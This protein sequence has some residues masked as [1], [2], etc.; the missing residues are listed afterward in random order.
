MLRRLSSLVTVRVLCVSLTLLGLS[1]VV[2]AESKV[3]SGQAVAKELGLPPDARHGFADADGVPIHFVEIG[4]GPLLIMIHGF[5][6]YWYSWRKQMPKLSETHHV[7]AIDQRGYNHSGQPNG[8]D[9]YRMDRLVD[10]I[11]AVVNHFEEER[12]IIVGHDWGG[13]VAW[14]TAMEHPKL[15]EQLVI[16]NLPHPQ[17]LARELANNAQQQKASGYARFFQTEAAAKTLS[18][19]GLAFWVNDVE[20]RKHY[21][22]AFERSSFESMLNYYKANYPKEPYTYN[23]DADV[24]LIKCPVLMIHGLKDSALLPGALNDTWRYLERDLTLIT[25]PDANHFVQQD[26][27]ELVTNR[28]S[29]WLARKAS[30]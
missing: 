2:I 22:Q 7:V 13:A 29:Q 23:P 25:V 4:E 8:V 5:P 26:S 1:Q 21:I 14:Q 6:D 19:E 15:V 10:D 20:A 30:P 24:P 18:A 17:A 28:I 16:L 27:A 12:A 9:N 3:T 11:V